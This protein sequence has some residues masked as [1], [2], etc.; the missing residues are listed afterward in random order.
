MKTALLAALCTLSS[1][2]QPLRGQTAGGG[3]GGTPAGDVEPLFEARDALFM[4]G[5]GVATLAI[6]PFDKE[7]A[8]YLQGDPQARRFLR[9]MFFAVERI[10]LPGAFII[11]G[12]LYGAGKL[13]GNDEMADVGLHGTEAIVIG[14]AVTSVIKFS[15]GRA[16][17]Y[18]NREDP[19][20]FKFMRGLGKEEYRSFPSGHTLI[21]FAA[22]S[23][24]TDESSRFWPEAQWLLGPV[25]YGGAALVGVSRMYNNK[26]WASDVIMG[27]AIGVF[28]G[29]KVVKYHHSRPRN[30][31]DRWLLGVSIG[32]D[33]FGSRTARLIL[34]PQ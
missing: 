4:G 13:S 14:L 3:S 6:A 19:Y 21:A 32:H 18:V 30:R 23:A 25:L 28:S 33:E 17:P 20:N 16:R 22:A 29:L 9:R 15:A 31:I 1:A 10:A 27:G 12:G 7:F 5:V 8:D 26:H 24:V 34:V 11:G 2:V